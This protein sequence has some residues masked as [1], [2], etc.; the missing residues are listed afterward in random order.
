M[1]WR[2]GV[3]AAAWWRGR[4]EEV[5]MKGK[6]G[7]RGAYIREGERD[8]GEEGRGAVA[9]WRRRGG[10]AQGSTRRPRRRL[11]WRQAAGG[12]AAAERSGRV[13]QW[14]WQAT[15]GASS[16]GRH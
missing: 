8:N 14:R 11:R 5:R 10:A 7:S 6:R 13:E 9:S 3:E 16:S 12:A 15:G 1:R 4:G 2:G